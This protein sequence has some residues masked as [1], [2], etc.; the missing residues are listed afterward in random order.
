VPVLRG[1]IAAF[2]GEDGHDIAPD[3]L[4]RSLAA[5]AER[6]PLLRVWMIEREGRALGYVALAL[7]YSIE[8]GGLDAFVDELYLLPE[9][10]AHGLGSAALAFVE[11]EA[12]ALGV[13]RLCLEVELHNLRAHALYERHGYTAH[14]RHLMSKRLT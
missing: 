1:F 2:N 13:R 10:R 8:V 5:V 7:G 11:R 3:V 14:S 4:E 9:E 12:R 6:E